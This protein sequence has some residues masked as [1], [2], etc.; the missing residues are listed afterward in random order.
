[1]SVCLCVCWSVCLFDQDIGPAKVPFDSLDFSLT[2]LA[3]REPCE[4]H[5]FML[6]KGKGK[7]PMADMY[8]YPTRKYKPTCLPPSS[9][10]PHRP[11]YQIPSKSIFILVPIL[12]SAR[13]YAGTSIVALA[14]SS[15]SS[16]SFSSSELS[17]PLNPPRWIYPSLE[18]RQP[19][20][21]SQDRFSSRTDFTV[22][23]IHPSMV[24]V[25]AHSVRHR[26]ICIEST[27]AKSVISHSTRPEPAVS[28]HPH[29]FTP[30]GHIIAYPSLVCLDRAPCT[31]S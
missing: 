5:V 20:P 18:S 23:N 25:D 1:M 26:G 7:R 3:G 2:F 27:L 12:K 9:S 21:T 19:L 13:S 28:I 14:S 29:P 4:I 8:S 22:P 17:S 10:Y 30:L 11:Y 16:S 6:G 31:P 15:S 24:E